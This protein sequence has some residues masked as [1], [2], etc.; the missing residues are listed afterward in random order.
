MHIFVILK[1][2]IYMVSIIFT[3]YLLYED[4]LLFLSKPTYSSNSQ[5]TLQPKDYPNILL[6]PFPSFD[7]SQLNKYGYSEAYTY[8]KGDLKG[9][10]D[11]SGG[12]SGNSSTCIE[13]VIQDISVLKSIENCPKMEAIFTEPHLEWKDWKFEKIDFEIT[14]LM[15]P[16]GKCCQAK[17][18]EKAKKSYVMKETK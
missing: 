3:F 4:I 15:Y 5:V 16:H 18:P 13:D 14:N 6:C 2:K 8:C 12:W 9:E 7:I 11:Y 10:G 1:F 17:I